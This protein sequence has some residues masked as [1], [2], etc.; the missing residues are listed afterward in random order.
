MVANGILIIMR[1]IQIWIL[2]K[3]NYQQNHLNLTYFSTV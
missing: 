1:L 3:E 2:E